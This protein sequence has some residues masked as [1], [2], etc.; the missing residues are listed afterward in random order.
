MTKLE[1]LDQLRSCLGQLPPE[2]AEKAAIY[3]GELIDDMTEDGYTE[4][5]AVQALAPPAQAARQVLEELP[6]STLVKSRA[7]PKKGW[8]PA[9]IVLAAVG[10]PIWISIGLALLAVVLS[11]YIVIWAVVV[12]LFAVTLAVGLSSL[13]AIASPLFPDYVYGISPV[14]LAGFGIA[15][16][17]V[18]IL[19]FLASVA[20]AKLTAR[21]SVR[22][23][24]RIKRFFIK[25]EM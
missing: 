17:G 15:G 7:K 18:T 20:L 23:C 14:T 2:E 11:V 25:E 12:V 21:L 5:E 1:Y 24:R 19:L 9:A 3:Y 10:S 16:L 8:T 6:L 22:I 4:Q 13:A